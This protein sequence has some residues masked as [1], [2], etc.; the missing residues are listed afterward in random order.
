M[1]H[2]LGKDLIISSR[3]DGGEKYIGARYG[4]ILPVVE[5]AIK[6]TENDREISIALP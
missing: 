5:T 4:F 3:L 6:F 2:C 1:I